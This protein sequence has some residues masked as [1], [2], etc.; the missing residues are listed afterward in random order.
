LI[1]TPY[2]LGSRSHYAGAQAWLNYNYGLLYWLI[3]YHLLTFAFS[4]RSER[5]C[6]L[7]PFKGRILMGETVLCFNE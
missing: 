7:L 2:T 6:C 5:T 3:K 4:L 1:T